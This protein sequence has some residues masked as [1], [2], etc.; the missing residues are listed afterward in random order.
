MVDV[1]PVFLPTKISDQHL[2]TALATYRLRVSNIEYLKKLSVHQKK[3]AVQIVGLFFRSLI[4]KVQLRREALYGH[5]F[6]GQD[7]AASNWL[8]EYQDGGR[9]C[10]WQCMRVRPLQRVYGW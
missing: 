10:T 1:S 3:A 4:R 7:L 2:I 6:R 9:W 8:P 5:L